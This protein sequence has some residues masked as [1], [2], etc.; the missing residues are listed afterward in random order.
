MSL[1]YRNG[2]KAFATDPGLTRGKKAN[3]LW[4]PLA[5]I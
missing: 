1:L 5:V 2:A 4:L 3:H